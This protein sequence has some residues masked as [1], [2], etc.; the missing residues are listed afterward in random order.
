[1]GVIW[2]TK[3]K[4]INPR[5]PSSRSILSFSAR[6]S[7][8]TFH[9]SSNSS[10]TAAPIGQ[11]SCCPHVGRNARSRH[12]LAAWKSHPHGSCMMLCFKGTLRPNMQGWQGQ[13]G[14]GHSELSKLGRNSA[15]IQ[16]K[17]PARFTRRSF[18][19]ALRSRG[20]RPRNHVVVRTWKIKESNRVCS[21]LQNLELPAGP[22]V[23]RYSEPTTRGLVRDQT[24]CTGGQ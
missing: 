5:R 1:M 22:S 12:P 4:S 21:Q 24:T 17:H 16:G 15:V 13:T 6:N 3:P 20:F 19:G 10:T 2:A 7:A 8:Q 14:P 18:S 23:L 11:D 9:N